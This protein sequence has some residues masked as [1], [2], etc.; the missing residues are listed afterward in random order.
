[1]GEQEKA[2]EYLVKAIGMFKKMGMASD[3]DQAEQ[4]LPNL[5][6]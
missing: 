2:K 6:L 1:M 5:R 3:L 4:S